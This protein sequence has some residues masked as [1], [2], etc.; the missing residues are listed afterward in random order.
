[1]S[2]QNNRTI[3][4]RIHALPLELEH[5]IL[6]CTLASTIPG[7]HVV[8]GPPYQAPWQLQ[9]N[10]LTRIRLAWNYFRSRIFHIPTCA[11]YIS[12]LVDFR[13][14]YNAQSRD[15]TDQIRNI[16]IYL[17]HDCVWFKHYIQQ[18]GVAEEYKRVMRVVVDTLRSFMGNN[19]PAEIEINVEL[20]AGGWIVVIACTPTRASANMQ[21]EIENRSRKQS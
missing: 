21:R 15:L 5:L 19:H 9:V 20:D 16:R 2:N 7:P 4:D 1:M 12:T 17:Q 14:W 6:E 3:E 13:R 11:C 8:V 10:K 18:H